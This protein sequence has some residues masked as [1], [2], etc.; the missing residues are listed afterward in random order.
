MPYQAELLRDTKDLY[1]DTTY[2]SNSSF[3]YLFNM[4]AFNETTMAYN[5]VARVLLN[6][7]DGDAYATAISEVFEYVAKIHP[8]FKNGQNLRQIMVDFD[9]AEYN[10]FERC[11]GSNMSQKIL[12]GSTVH[13]KTSVNSA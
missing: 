10:G 5:V 13:W 7:Q 6:K 2:T 12:R 8:S 1:V 11:M 3:Q 9:Q 4:V